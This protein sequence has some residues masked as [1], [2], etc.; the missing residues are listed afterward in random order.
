[1][2]SYYGSKSKIINKYPAPKH[3]TIIEPFCGSARYSLKYWGW[4][5][6]LYDLDSDV[7]AV[8]EWLINDACPKDILT[9]PIVKAG[10]P[11]PDMG[12]P[13]A[14]KFLAYM[15]NQGSSRPKRVAGR[16]N[17]CKW[18]PSRIAELLPLVKHWS[19]Q[20]GSYQDIPNY[21]D[22]TWYV[23][24]PYQ[25]Q[26]RWYR[27]NLIDYLD[28]AKWCKSRL[29]QVIVCENSGADW[30]PFRDLTYVNGQSYTTKEVIWMK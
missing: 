24:P 6:M 8:W 20:Q 18:T 15:S 11:I 21:P 10:M 4:D 28:L 9:M 5:V 12:H 25:R 30:L 19:I 2:F 23:D 14:T 27:H 13:A 29:G 17:F 26:G 22:C 16:M 7:V 3:K 1:M